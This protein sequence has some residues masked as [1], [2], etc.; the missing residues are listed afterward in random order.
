MPLERLC[1]GWDQPEGGQG[2]HAARPDELA[3]LALVRRWTNIFLA[4]LLG[5]RRR[6]LPRSLVLFRWARRMGL[7][8]SVHLAISRADFAGDGH[9][10]V[11]LEG[12]PLFEAADPDG[13]FAELH[14]YP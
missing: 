4:V 8:A 14:R 13:R 7:V 9:A 6:C 1:E 12:R 5:N 2:S 10:W 11:E 3:T